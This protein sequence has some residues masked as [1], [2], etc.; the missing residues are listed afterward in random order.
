MPEPASKIAIVAYG[1]EIHLYDA[2]DEA[3]E[4]VYTVAI[5]ANMDASLVKVSES[6]W[7]KIR[8]LLDA[9]GLTI[10]DHRPGQTENQA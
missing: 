4:I 7:A 9:D 8:G 2:D 5:G 3:A 1:L 10:T 6:G